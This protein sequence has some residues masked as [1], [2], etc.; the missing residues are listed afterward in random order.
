MLFDCQCVPGLEPSLA[1]RMTAR[2]LFA[3][4]FASGVLVLL[5]GVDVLGR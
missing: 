1:V 4:A 3:L 2:I 5:A